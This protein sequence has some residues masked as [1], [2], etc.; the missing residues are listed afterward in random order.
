MENFIN[1]LSKQRFV[2]WQWMYNIVWFANISSLGDKRENEK[3]SRGVIKSSADFVFKTLK[4]HELEKVPSN[5]KSEKATLATIR[6]TGIQVIYGMILS[7]YCLFIKC[8]KVTVVV[9]SYWPFLWL[10]YCKWNDPRRT[11]F[12]ISAFKKKCVCSGGGRV[13]NKYGNKPEHSNTA[14]DTHKQ[15]NALS[16]L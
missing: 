4:R 7:N 10:K 11:C 1:K 15:N 6:E 16:C 9:F 14:V 3:C 2:F 12:K 13:D 5:K 8:S